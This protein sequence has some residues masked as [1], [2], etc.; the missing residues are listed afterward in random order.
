MYNYKT[1]FETGIAFIAF[2]VAAGA[3][4][5]GLWYAF[6]SK[7]LKTLKED[8]AINKRLLEECETK[9]ILNEQKHLEN[10]ARIDN[11]QGQLDAYSKL[12]L[13]PKKFLDKI[14]KNQ[15]EIIKALKES[16]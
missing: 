1:I 16:K 4:F 13:V 9:H 12:I 5:G 14:D 15:Q 6:R 10:E 8:V 7:E 11:L 3:G 2:M